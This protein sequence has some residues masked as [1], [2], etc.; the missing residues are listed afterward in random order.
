MNPDLYIAAVGIAVTAVGSY[1]TLRFAW[2]RDQVT[3]EAGIATSTGDSIATVMQG[4]SNLNTSL[5][6]ERDRQQG[7]IERLEQRMETEAEECKREIAQLR[8][9]LRSAGIES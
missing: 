6:A 7:R 2:K 4:F 9:Q 5:Q 8:E 3:K 1:F